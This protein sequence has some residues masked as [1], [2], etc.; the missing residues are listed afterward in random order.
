VNKKEGKKINREDAQLL[1]YV[2]ATAG[3]TL[4]KAQMFKE[5]QRAQITTSAFLKIAKGC[6]DN[7]SVE[8]FH[9][10]VIDTVYPLLNCQ[11]VT[12]YFCDDNAKE[13]VIAVSK[14]GMAGKRMKYGK[15]I[16]GMCALTGKVI[17]IKDAYTNCNFFNPDFDKNAG[18]QT[19]TVLCVPIFAG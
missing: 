14:D 5:T 3:I 6:S 1:S 11:R 19:H 16:A 9:L 7:M 13:I 10:L 18:F 15:G 17:N 8:E 4:K 12:L 2:A